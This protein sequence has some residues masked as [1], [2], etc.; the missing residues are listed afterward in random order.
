MKKILLLLSFF[1]FLKSADF[2][3]FTNLVSHE[4]GQNIYLDKAVNDYD[5][6]VEFLPNIAKP[7]ELLKVYRKVLNEHN[8]TLIFDK[9]DKFYYVE[10]KKN[11]E[12]QKSY[13]TY[14]VQNLLS[15]DI[16]DLLTIF[17][18]L[19]YKFLM[20]SD[21]IV[22]N[23]TTKESKNILKLLSTSDLKSKQERIRITVLNT[24]NLKAK[25][26]GTRIKKIG[27]NF[28]YFL[29]LIIATPLNNTHTISHNGTAGSFNAFL[30]MMNNEG[31]TE[32]EQS[33]TMLLRDGKKTEF[34]S[35]TNIPFLSQTQQVTDTRTNN[36]ESLEY[37]DVGL[38]VTVL[39]KI[40]NNYIYLDL[41]LVS[42]DLLTARS[43]IRPVTQKIEYTNSI[44][45]LKH[46]S[47][48]L[49]GL[50]KKSIKK[51]GFKVPILGDIPILDV[52]FDYRSESEAIE[53]VS[54]LIESID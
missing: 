36:I 30:T 45:L 46:E 20:Q 52:L 17:P 37:K 41:K 12:P 54:I 10:Y 50:R 51:T 5:L 24:N 35:V 40:K 25:E 18:N 16:A 7:K 29:N 15:K 38:T 3:E 48:L 53:N 23:A 42:E 33:P 9:T 49:T 34:K 27:L 31:I 13:F 1:S 11:F 39:P 6:N 21:T 8:L 43:D 47:I 44:K 14:K 22:F 4:L 26:Y 2:Y 19:E 32:I 28:D